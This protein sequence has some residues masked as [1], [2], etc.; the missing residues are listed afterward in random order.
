M[1]PNFFSH[2]PVALMNTNASNQLRREMIEKSLET[3]RE[4]REKKTLSIEYRGID[5]ALEVVRIHPQYLLLNHD[6][7]R[8]S[9]QLFDHPERSVVMDDPSSSAAQEILASLLRKTE[10]FN[11]LKDELRELSQQNAGLIS[12]DGLLINGNTRVVALRDLGVDGVDVGVLPA[13]AMAKDFLDLEMSLQ[14]RR[15]THQDYTFTNELLLIEKY[16]NAGHTDKELARKMGWIRGWQKKVNEASQLLQLVKEIRKLSSPPLAYSVF[17]TK[18]QHLKD[19]NEEY[20]SMA[21]GS[22][23]G[24]EKMKWGRVAAMFL[25]VNK[26]QTRVIDEDFFE[27]DVLKRVGA[28]SRV[29]QVLESCKRVTVNDNL[30][31]LLGTDEPDDSIDLR[32]FTEK[33][34]I[35][36]ADDSGAIKNDLTSELQ[37]IYKAVLLGAEAAITEKKRKKLLL[38]PAGVLK[39][40]RISLEELLMSFSEVSGLQ[41][42]D[43]NNFAFELSKVTS[44][45]EEIK[46]MFGKLK[47]M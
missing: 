40:T 4:R 19:L 30:G 42:F 6:N 23:E 32:K 44:C 20:Q 25:G 15:L 36:L 14:M 38:E 17:D 28:K 1:Q 16:R 45:I 29:F 5:T 18:S 12:R 37:E 8:L 24:A 39:E 22:H 27:E 47:R 31:D 10:R 13:D 43:A 41:D 2:Q 21:V 26:D 46:N 11:K 35:E 34:I 33:V 3:Y 9:A 7:S